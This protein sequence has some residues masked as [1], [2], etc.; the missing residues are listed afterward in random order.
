MP[1]F[2][3]LSGTVMDRSHQLHKQDAEVMH[4]TATA[5]SA[6]PPSACLLQPGKVRYREAKWWGHGHPPGQQ[7]SWGGWAAGGPG[8]PG[9]HGA[10]TYP[11]TPGERE[12]G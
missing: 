8:E 10:G 6:Q 2:L 7:Q 12:T 3:I 4:P 9:E 5:S 1:S 11:R